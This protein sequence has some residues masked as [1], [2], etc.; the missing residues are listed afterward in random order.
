VIL[1]DKKTPLSF[2][3]IVIRTVAEWAL[4][5]ATGVQLERPLFDLA[6]RLTIVA[7]M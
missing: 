7:R 2:S 3:L 4:V 5:G 1:K 6:Y